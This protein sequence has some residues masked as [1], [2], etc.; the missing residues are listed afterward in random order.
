MRRRS[1]GASTPTTTPSSRSPTRSPRSRPASA[2]C[3]RRSTATASGA[4]TRTWSRSSPTSR[5]R[6]RRPLMPAGGGSLADLT[7]LSRSVA[8]IANVAPNDYQPY[9]GRSAFAHKGGVHGAAVAKVERSYQHVDPS[10]VGNAGRLVVSELGGKA[11]TEIRAR[12]LGHD[13]AGIVD[14]RELSKIIKQLEHEGLAFEGAEASFELLIR[15]Q[16]AD[17]AA[18]V[19]DRRLHLS[20]GAAVR[21]RAPRRGDGQ[22]R[23]RGRGAP[24]RRRRQRPGQRARRRAAQGAPGVLPAARH[25]PPRRLQ[26]PHPRRGDRHGGPDARHH[27]FARTAR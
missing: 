8:E 15:R 27:R 14:P 5:S 9:V 17:Y 21:P 20:R 16:A 25:G 12:Q 11:N 19:P 13:L 2:T 22:G 4:A 24:H 6:P 26:G 1:R 10:S 18:A 3:R 7:E 23:G